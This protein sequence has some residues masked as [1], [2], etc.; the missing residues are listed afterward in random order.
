MKRL[1]AVIACLWLLVGAGAVWGR[2]STRPRTTDTVA[3]ARLVEARAKVAATRTEEVRLRQRQAALTAARDAA[4]ARLSRLLA[5]L[6]PLRVGDL[7]GGRTPAADWAEADRR[8]VW[9]RS[10]FDAARAAQAAYTADSAKAYEGRA[11]LDSAVKRL[12]LGRGEADAAFSDVLTRRMGEL[13]PAPAAD[14]LGRTLGEADQG[15]AAQPFVAPPDGLT[16]PVDGPVVTAF[17]PAG[18]SP[19]QG[20]ILAAREGSQVVAATTGR[21]AYSGMLRGLGRVVILSHDGLLHTV[22]ACLASSE[23]SLGDTVSRG[24]LLGRSGVCGLSGKPGVYFELRFREKAL[25]PAEWF[26][27]RR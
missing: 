6:W 21:V 22:Y 5:A 23:A 19:R 7:S 14:V 26:A 25:N 17:A 27:A 12:D 13:E 18:R 20:V 16:R 8:Y 4:L 11:A 3:A 1:T 2:G 15:E 10:L 24:G 9:T